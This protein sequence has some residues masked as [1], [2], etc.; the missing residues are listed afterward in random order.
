MPPMLMCICVPLKNVYLLAYFTVTA[1]TTPPTVSDT[2]ISGHTCS[3]GC[4][5]S[6]GRSPVIML[7]CEKN[8]TVNKT[9]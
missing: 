2:S 9:G 7:K 6:P 4:P 1:I 5:L 3:R 8:N